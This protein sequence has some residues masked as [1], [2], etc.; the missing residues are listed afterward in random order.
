ME[1]ILQK[2]SQYLANDKCVE[3]LA[4]LV[5]LVGGTVTLPSTS[6]VASQ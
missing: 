1:L 4:A 6:A 5:A 2:T 3:Y